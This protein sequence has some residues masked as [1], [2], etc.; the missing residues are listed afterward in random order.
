MGLVADN[1]NYKDEVIHG[2]TV[3]NDCGSLFPLLR[4]NGDFYRLCA[5]FIFRYDDFLLIICTVFPNALNL[6]PTVF[7]RD[8]VFTDMVKSPVQDRHTDE[9]AS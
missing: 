5:F 6:R 2:Y 9:R 7:P 4:I 3:Y 8:N 1:P